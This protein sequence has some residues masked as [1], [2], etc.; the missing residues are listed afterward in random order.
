[1]SSQ[2]MKAKTWAY[3][4]LLLPPHEIVKSLELRDVGACLSRKIEVPVNDTIVIL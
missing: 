1:M 2:I 3:M 4:T